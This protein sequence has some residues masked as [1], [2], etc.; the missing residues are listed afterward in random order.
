M[1]AN[2]KRDDY[3]TLVWELSDA[4]TT[5]ILGNKVAALTPEYIRENA[6]SIRGACSSLVPCIGIN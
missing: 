4:E 5:R 3:E 2:F 6:S 1:A